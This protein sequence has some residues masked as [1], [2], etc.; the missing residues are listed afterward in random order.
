MAMPRNSLSG[1]ASSWRLYNF[2]VASRCCALMLLKRS[3][4]YRCA[5]KA[6]MMR[7]PDMASSKWLSNFP[8]RPCEIRAPDRSARVILPMSNA[9][10][11]RVSNVTN[12]NF[13]LM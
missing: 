11:G 9:D 6:L 5:L 13:G 3:R 10:T 8:R 4:T 2:L 1:E 7:I 12:V